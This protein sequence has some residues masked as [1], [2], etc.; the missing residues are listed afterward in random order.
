MESAKQLFVTLPLIFLS[1]AATANGLVEKIYW[2]DIVS[3]AIFRANQDG[4][5]VEELVSTN[6]SVVGIA[7]DAI[8]GKMYWTDRDAQTTDPVIRRGN[9]DGSSAQD[10]IALPGQDLTGIDLDLTNGKI[11]WVIRGGL[12]AGIKRTN[13]DG[14]S[15]VEDIVTRDTADVGTPE[16][17]ALDLV[18]GKVYWTDNSA[19]KIQRANLDGSNVEVLL[20]S[21]TGISG[22]TLW[23]I[24]LD[25]KNAKM[26]WGEGD[27]IEV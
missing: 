21:N 27:M 12:D 1:A 3:Q 6:D 24:E 17:I 5:N 26:Y 18:S 4:T 25:L 22:A 2:T 10:L 14:S 7:V 9:L 15:G 19:K 20:T 11:Y 8:N 16:G 13:I 23:E